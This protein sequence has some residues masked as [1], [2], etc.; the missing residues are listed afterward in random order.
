MIRKLLLANVSF[1]LKLEQGLKRIV[2]LGWNFPLQSAGPGYAID[3]QQRGRWDRIRP[4]APHNS[5]KAA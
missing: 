2:S 4:G 3:A 1:S 5:V